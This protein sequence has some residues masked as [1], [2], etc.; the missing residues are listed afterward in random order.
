MSHPQWKCS[1]WCLP[2][3]NL[4]A[5]SLGPGHLHRAEKEG[6]G[7]SSTSCF[8]V[9]NGY[10]TA[11]AHQRAARRG[12][13]NPV[14][15]SERPLGDGPSDILSFALQLGAG[16]QERESIIAENPF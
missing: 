10:R 4:K 9:M 6:T 11:A 7:F 2:S 16:N 13:L 1:I 12:P 15:S 14:P 5:P 8:L 3:E